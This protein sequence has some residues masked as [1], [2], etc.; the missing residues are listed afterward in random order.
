MNPSSSNPAMNK[1]VRQIRLSR[2]KEQYAVKEKTNKLGIGI[3][4]AI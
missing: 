1:I 4:E 3:S 2:L